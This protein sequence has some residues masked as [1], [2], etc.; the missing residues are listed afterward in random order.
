MLMG[1]FALIIAILGPFLVLISSRYDRKKVLVG[2]L[3]GFAVCSALSAYAP[4]FSSLMALRI[5]PALLHPVFFSA[6]FTAAASLYPK[7]RA[8][9]AMAQAF[10]GTS[11]GL[12]LGV[13]ATTWVAAHI[14]YE[15]SFLFCSAATVI[16][17]I[18]LM[19]M[20]PGQGRPV[21]LSFGR[22]LAVLRKPALWLN[23][24]ATV[25]VFTA[26]FCV[27]SYAAQYLKSAT[28]MDA[29]TTS[30]VL[31]IFGI[32][33]VSG[34]LLA[35]RLLGRNMVATTLLHPVALG[36]AYLVLLACGSA[37]LGSMAVIAV[38]WGATHTSG[39]L[40]S[41]VWL[42][43]EAREAP[44]FATSLFVSAGNGGVV[45]GSAIGGIFIN[46]FGLQGIVWCGLIFCVLSVLAI[47]AKVLLYPAPLLP[48]GAVHVH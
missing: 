12:V 37:N 28:G 13:P 8:A 33:G 29:T 11:F 5:V 14:S 6:A 15:A 40:I 23:I 20:L 1:V 3:F 47:G 36:L 26:M 24:V 31:L 4:N 25:L 9:H 39:M 46:A 43:S 30:L 38:L 48:E 7:E 16:A 21:A 19:L 10:V 17:G 45:L 35:G 41:Q 34:N 27:Y 18:G 22:Q 44:E 32:G 2:A 42:T